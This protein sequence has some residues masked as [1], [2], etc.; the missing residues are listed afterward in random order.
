MW[1]YTQG[2]TDHMMIQFLLV[3]KSSKPFCE[4]LRDKKIAQGAV[5][6]VWREKRGMG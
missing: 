4:N 6:V 2:Q 3:F 1:K 5:V